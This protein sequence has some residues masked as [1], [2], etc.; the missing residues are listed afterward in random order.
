[1]KKVISIIFI[2]LALMSTAHA[3]QLVALNL[4]QAKSATLFLL[5][6]NQL[7]LFCSCCDPKTEK[8][9]CITTTNVWYER[10]GN[11]QDED[12]YQIFVSGHKAWSHDIDTFELDLAYT[13]YNSNGFARCVATGLWGKSDDVE[14]CNGIEYFTWDKRFFYSQYNPNPLDSKD[15]TPSIYSDFVIQN[16]RKEPFSVYING[17]WVGR[18]S[19]YGELTIKDQMACPQTT[20]KV[21]QEAGYLLYPSEYNHTFKEVLWGMKY[22][23]KFSK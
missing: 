22:T 10:F 3:D 15:N 14:V 23:W 21:V 18:V 6:Q 8:P 16:N 19:G 7:I 11:F 12:L 17:K 1:M 13:Y 2:Y 5:N 20:I 4:R 9:I